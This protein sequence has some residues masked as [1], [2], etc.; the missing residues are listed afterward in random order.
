MFIEPNDF[1]IVDIPKCD[2]S[3]W[4]EWLEKTENKLNEIGYEKYN[5]NH[6]REDFAYWKPFYRKDDKVYQIGIFFYDFRK[7]RHH[8]TAANYISVAYE[9][10]LLGNGNRIVLEVEKGDM[11]VLKFEE[12]GKDF[13]YSMLPYIK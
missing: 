3:D 11:T 10:M 2:S 13:Y 1:L 12:M 7:Y 4:D 6:K 5:Q 9:C 8:D